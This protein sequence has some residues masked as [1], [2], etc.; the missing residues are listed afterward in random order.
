LVGT[1][2]AR[3]AAKSFERLFKINQLWAA[4]LHLRRPT[5]ELC[6]FKRRRWLG[7]VVISAGVWARSGTRRARGWVSAGGVISFWHQAFARDGSRRFRASSYVLFAR[8]FC[9]RVLIST[10]RLT[11]RWSRRANCPWE[12][13]PAARG[14]A[15]AVSQIPGKACAQGQVVDLAGR[16][17]LLTVTD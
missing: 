15:R 5:P 17:D 9:P 16:R 4:V 8:A 2:F 1:C 12:R 14:S 11:P 3:R 10:R 6:F 13:A 7:H